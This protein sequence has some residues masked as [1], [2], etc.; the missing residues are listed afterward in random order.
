MKMK[1]LISFTG[2]GMTLSKGQEVEMDDKSGAR[3]DLERLG[4]LE[5]VTEKK[6]AKAKA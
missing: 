5:P 3:F 2:Y 6:T 4:W 1:A